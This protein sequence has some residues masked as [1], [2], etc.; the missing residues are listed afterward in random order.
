MQIES[1]K[2]SNYRVF[3]NIEVNHIPNLA[4][5]L[6]RNGSGKTTFFDIFGF[7]HDALQSNIRAALAK[8]GGFSEVISL[9][10]L[11]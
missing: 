7:L 8:R 6:G 1:I 9:M 11:S 10:L 4:I 3:H 5:F 2:V